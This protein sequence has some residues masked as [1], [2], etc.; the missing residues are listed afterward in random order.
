MIAKPGEPSS[1]NQRPITCL[2]SIF[3]WFISFLQGPMDSHLD[4]RELMEGEKNGG[5]EG[6]SG[7]TDNLM[8][9]KITP[10]CH[11]GKMNL[12][13]AWIDVRKACDTVG[14]EWLNEMMQVHR[15][16]GWLCRV[17]QNLSAC[18]NTRIVA[19]TAQGSGTSFDFTRDFHWGRPLPA[20]IYV[21]PKLCCLVSKRLRRV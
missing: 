16:P 20:F 12:S 5:K 15:F 9:D 21:M 14:Y 19:Q 7:T 4:Q 10:D 8:R 18:W 6:C 13:M 11:R 2:N 1:E 3:K 17:I